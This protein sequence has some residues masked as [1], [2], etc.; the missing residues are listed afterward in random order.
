[1]KAIY[2]I[3]VGLV[4]FN[5]M[6]VVTTMIGVFNYG[7]PLYEGENITEIND[8]KLGNM[9]AKDLWK[10]LGFDSANPFANIAAIVMMGVAIAA[11]YFFRSPVPLGIGAFASFFTVVWSVTVGTL[12]QFPIPSYLLA[13]GTVGIGILFVI[14]VI[15]MATG[16][17]NG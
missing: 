8:I 13:A 6:M 4:I 12:D 9:T 10:V 2:V 3:L 15:E 1:M 16:G 17:H 14:N 11:S 7:G 5:S